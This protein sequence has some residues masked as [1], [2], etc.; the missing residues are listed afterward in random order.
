RCRLRSVVVLLRCLR[1]AAF[2]CV[3]RP[4]ATGARTGRG[5]ARCREGVNGSPL[6]VVAC[7]R[8]ASSTILVGA[9]TRAIVTVPGPPVAL[10]EDALELCRG[11]AWVHV[12][13]AGY[14]AAPRDVRLSIDGGNPIP[15]LDLRG[16]ALYAPTE[17]ALDEAFR[18]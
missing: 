9:G 11:A 2:L 3:G 10:R 17:Q 4:C 8:S 18:G 6:A 7:A 1:P 13:H 12:D 15:D 5:G 16:V 14:A